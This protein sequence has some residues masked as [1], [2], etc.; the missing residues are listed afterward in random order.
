[1]LHLTWADSYADFQVNHTQCTDLKRT[2]CV[3]SPRPLFNPNWVL[4][5]LFQWRLF[6]SLKFSSPTRKEYENNIH[7]FFGTCSLWEP[8]SR[9]LP[10]SKDIISQGAGAQTQKLHIRPLQLTKRKEMSPFLIIAV[11][12]PSSFTYFPASLFTSQASFKSLFLY[13]VASCTNVY[14]T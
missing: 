4:F 8:T 7:S 12:F 14:H 5:P 2:I 9:C 1:M 13:I 3:I 11:S 10:P 6:L